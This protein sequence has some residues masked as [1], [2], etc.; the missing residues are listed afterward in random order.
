M[1]AIWRKVRWS[2]AQRGWGGTVRAAVRALGRRVR[3]ERKEQERHPFDVRYGVETSGVI[4][5]GSLGVGH[6]HDA[7]ITAYVGIAPSRFRAAMERWRTEL[8][9]ARVEEVAFVDLGCGKGRAL[10][11]ASEWPFREA[12]GVELNPGL[13][14]IAER[15]VEIWQA[16]GRA[17]CAMRV[18]CGDAT[19][20]PLPDGP[21]LLFLYN[22]FAAP[23]VRALAERL[24][25]RARSGG[26]RVD[27]LYQNAVFGGI[28][29][30]V[31]GMRE[32]WAERMAMSEE[33]GATDPSASPEDV[34]AM[35]SSRGM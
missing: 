23:V 4:G 20:R 13:A 11:M 33:D 22:A 35:Y 29:R 18:E 7:Y 17:R 16:A 31:G 28:L 30:E 15:N 25:E 19:E 32:V 27:V 12:V 3:G 26:G 24:A 2:V 8:G 21:C 10:L 5:G 14:E 1:K 9:D 34:T 6:A